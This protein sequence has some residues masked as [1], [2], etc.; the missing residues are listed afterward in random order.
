MKKFK[1]SRRILPALFS[2][3]AFTVNAQKLPNVQQSSLCAPVDI[4]IDG[5]A[6]EWDDKYQAYNKSTELFY[7][8]SNDNNNLYLIV[9]AIKPRIIQKIIAVGVTLIVNNAGKKSDKA[10]ENAVITYPFLSFKNGEN[11]IS[12]TGLKSVNIIPKFNDTAEEILI[13]QKK[14]DSLIAIANNLFSNQSKLIK[15]KGLAGI[16][17]TAISVYNEQSIRT[18]ATFDNAKTYTYELSVPLKYLGLSI[19]NLQK[20]TYNIRLISRFDANKGRVSTYYRYG[21]GGQIDMNADLDAPTD[22]W[23]EYTLAKK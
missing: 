18:A 11:I 17:D 7:T 21:D 3:I 23:G 16:P 9:H 5:K 12:N 13:S 10:M 19:D 2:I 22:F 6:T 4:K 14:S 1:L 15:I 20:F 8:I